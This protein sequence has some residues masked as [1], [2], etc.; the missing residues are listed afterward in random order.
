MRR[1]GKSV[2]ETAFQNRTGSW[3]RD[4]VKVCF[5]FSLNS[6]LPMKTSYKILTYKNNQ[7]QKVL[8]F[9]VRPCTYFSGLTYSSQLLQGLYYSPLTIKHAEIYGKI[10]WTHVLEKQN[11]LPWYSEPPETAWV[12]GILYVNHLVLTVGKRSTGIPENVWGLK[13]CGWGDSSVFR[14]TCWPSGLGSA[15]LLTP[16]GAEVGGFLWGETR[17]TYLV[18]SRPA[19]ATKKTN[20]LFAALISVILNL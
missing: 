15:C 17:L 14:S 16:A 7:K 1:E 4:K 6:E 2:T 19:R 10:W 8:L 12:N 20:I 11:H 9:G 13:V 18:N 5:P 3:L